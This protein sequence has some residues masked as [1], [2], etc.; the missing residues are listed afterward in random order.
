MEVHETNKG[1]FK[2][3]LKGIP[4]QAFW[5]FYKANKEALRKA[6][7]TVFGKKLASSTGEYR[8]FKGRRYEVKRKE[9]EVTLWLNKLNTQLIA[10]AGF[11]LETASKSD[12]F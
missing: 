3:V 11:K 8:T 2:D 12:P 4:G 5:R 1:K 6:G 10:Q 9:W 7:L